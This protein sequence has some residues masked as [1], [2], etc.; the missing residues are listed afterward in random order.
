MHSEIR[1][2]VGLILI[3]LMGS[4]SNLHAAENIPSEKTMSENQNVAN[5]LQGNRTQVEVIKLNYVKAEDVAHVLATL[6]SEHATIIPYKASNSLIIKHR[7][8]VCKGLD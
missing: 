4:I 2:L 7:R 8:R 3:I 6:F 5:C 1:V